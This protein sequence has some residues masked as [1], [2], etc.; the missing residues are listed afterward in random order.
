MVVVQWREYLPPIIGSLVR[1]LD[2]ATC[3]G[4]VCCWF[5]PCPESFFSTSRYFGFSP[6]KKATFLNS[7]SIWN[8]RATGLSATLIKQSQFFFK[9]R[10][11]LMCKFNIE[12]F[13]IIYGDYRRCDLCSICF[14]FGI[15]NC[16]PGYCTAQQL[17]LD[18]CMVNSPCM[19]H[20]EAERLQSHSCTHLVLQRGPD[21]LN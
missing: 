8:P 16:E 14:L 17:C 19:V 20:T 13:S 10:L 1:F 5:F 21:I 18:F 4:S 12:T 15:V 3:V 7:N 11:N 6:P 9:E 2:V